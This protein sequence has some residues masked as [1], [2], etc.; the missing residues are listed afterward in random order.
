MATEAL[1]EL[2]RARA[3]YA[4]LAWGEALEAF[5]LTGR[6]APLGA[7][8]LERMATAA[9]MLG[10]MD[11]F[12]RILDLAHREHLEAGDWLRAARC[13]FFIGTNAAFRGEAALAAGWF[14]RAKR[15]VGR[16]GRECAEQGYLMLPDALRSRAAG[17]HEAAVAAAAGAAELGERFGDPD[18]FA[19]AVQAQGLALLE[20][21]RIEDGLG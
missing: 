18:L 19:L 15:L 11:E 1:P 20:G 13:G 7:D 5:E 9:F 16:E 21:G 4:G 10:R 3:A 6:L 8:D 14:A 12:T 17:D 2:D